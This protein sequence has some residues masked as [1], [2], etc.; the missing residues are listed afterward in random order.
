MCIQIRNTERNNIQLTRAQRERGAITLRIY[1]FQTI[2]MSD[3]VR[4]STI[5]VEF[6][7]N[8]PWLLAY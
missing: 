8:P 1:A 5:S 4:G 7:P 2:H 3:D 6:L